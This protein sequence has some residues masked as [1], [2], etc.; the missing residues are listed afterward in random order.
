[1]YYLYIPIY[2]HMHICIHAHMYMLSVLLL[3]LLLLLALLLLPL[4]LSRS[5]ICDHPLLDLGIDPHGEQQAMSSG[6]LG[7]SECRN[8]RICRH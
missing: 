2:M 3:L 7:I 1:M 8:A 6:Y 4:L 5:E